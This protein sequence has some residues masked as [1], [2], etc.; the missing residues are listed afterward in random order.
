MSYWKEV[1][2]LVGCG[3]VAWLVVTLLS[4]FR[5]TGCVKLV[6]ALRMTWVGPC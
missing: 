3:L 5:E 6:P 4:E 2:V 1:A